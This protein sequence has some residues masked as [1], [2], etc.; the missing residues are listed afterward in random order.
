MSQD[1]GRIQR[2]HRKEAIPPLRRPAVPQI[3]I[4]DRM[5]QGPSES[6]LGTREQRRKE[7][8]PP[9]LASLPKGEILHLAS[10]GKGAL[11]GGH[12]GR[13]HVFSHPFTR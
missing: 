7:L 2:H 11:R 4:Y 8:H 6:C 3:H 1:H 12:G 5:S 13:A 10:G 9:G